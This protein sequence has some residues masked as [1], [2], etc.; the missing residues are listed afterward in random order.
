MK[1]NVAKHTADVAQSVAQ[2]PRREYTVKSPIIHRGEEKVPGGKV[3]LTDRQADS[4]R[5]SGHIE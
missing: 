1:S 3:N 5:K 4:L 2:D